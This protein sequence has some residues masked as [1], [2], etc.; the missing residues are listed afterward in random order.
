MT[1]SLKVTE[2][3]RVFYTCF[4]NNK[5]CLQC[6]IIQI[7]AVKHQKKKST[8]F[9]QSSNK[10]ELQQQP[11]RWEVCIH[12][13][14]N[15]P[16]FRSAFCLFRLSWFHFCVWTLTDM[17]WTACSSRSFSFCTGAAPT[18]SNGRT[19]A[20]VGELNRT[21]L[22]CHH[23]HPPS[24]MLS[25]SVA[26]SINPHLRLASLADHVR[27]GSGYVMELQAWVI[28][29]FNWLWTLTAFPETGEHL[30]VSLKKKDDRGDNGGVIYL[31][32]YTIN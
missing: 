6:V 3:R 18:W 32:F 7:L 4:A 25:G 13:R 22:F 14:D 11:L 23:P 8:E 1:H 15:Q 2:E 28:L 5:M 16:A 10:S 9:C 17:W 19:A 20:S 27:P 30:S 26:C 24:W 31:F 29:H 21:G 12:V